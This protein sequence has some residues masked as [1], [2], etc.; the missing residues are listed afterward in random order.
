MAIIHVDLDALGTALST[1]TAMRDGI[2]TYQADLGNVSTQLGSALLD[3]T[4]ASTFEGHVS[5]ALTALTSLDT[6]LIDFVIALTS[7]QT[8]CN[9]CEHYAFDGGELV[10]C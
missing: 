8:D 3:S 5:T 9:W 6:A 10:I 1:L 7:V 4:N 2:N